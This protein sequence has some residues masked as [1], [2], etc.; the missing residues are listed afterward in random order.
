M[1]R[2]FPHQCLPQDERLINMKINTIITRLEFFSSL[3]LIQVCVI[4]CFQAHSYFDDTIEGP[5][6]YTSLRRILGCFLFLLRFAKFSACE[7]QIDRKTF[8]CI[9]LRWVSLLFQEITYMYAKNFKFTSTF[10]CCSF[11]EGETKE[12][13][14]FSNIFCTRYFLKANRKPAKKIQR[15]FFLSIICS[16]HAEN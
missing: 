13:F 4:H 6:T 12:I 2:F 16:S 11:V 7:L 5:G 3:V 9:F 14:C 1:Y 8:L 15:N 10:L